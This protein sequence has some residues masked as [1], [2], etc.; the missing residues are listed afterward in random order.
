[1]AAEVGGEDDVGL[2][3]FFFPNSIPPLKHKLTSSIP[4]LKHNS[5]LLTLI[6]FALLMR[7]F[8][9]ICGISNLRVPRTLDLEFG[10]KLFEL[11]MKTDRLLN[12]L[13]DLLIWNFF[14]V[15]FAFVGAR[16]SRI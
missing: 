4:P 12:R 8:V 14:S 1:M 16:G 7:H 13:W 15:W 2:L 3:F 9:R 6:Q 5:I 10:T 11:G